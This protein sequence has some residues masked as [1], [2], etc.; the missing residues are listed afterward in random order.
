MGHRRS[1]PAD[2][3]A[4]LT[5]L[6]LDHYEIC[7]ASVN[8]H[9]EGDYFHGVVD[10]K[11]SLASASTISRLRAVVQS[12]NTEFARNISQNGHKFQISTESPD[13]PSFTGNFEDRAEIETAQK[14][15][16]F[17]APSDGS[18]LST[19]SELEKSAED[20]EPFNPT[21]WSPVSMNREKSLEW[22]R[23]VLVWTR[24][25]ELVGSFNPLL[26]GELLWEQSSS[27][28]LFAAHHIDQVAGVCE[29]FLENLLEAKA[30]K[31]VKSRV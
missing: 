16:F 28:N 22:V 6:S 3:K 12:L 18:H 31:D 21:K 20:K 17:P 4:Y 15:Q 9:Y 10:N 27:W 8:G 5:Q 1:T 11:F 24:G 7:K 2:C 29:K 30:P 25:K 26:I 13:P 23:G 19:P 14:T